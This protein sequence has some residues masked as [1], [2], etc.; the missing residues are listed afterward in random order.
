M[1][2]RYYTKN[3]YTYII[4]FHK[5]KKVKIKI[6]KKYLSKIKKMKNTWVVN[7]IGNYYYAL[8]R[9]QSNN[10]RKTLYIHR[11]IMQNELEEKKQKYPDTDWE[12]DH[13][14]RNGLNNT[15]E[16]LRVV[17]KNVN[18]LNSN[19]EGKRSNSGYTGIYKI[20]LTNRTKFEVHFRGKYIALCDTLEEAL[21]ERKL[22][23]ISYQDTKN[24]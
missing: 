14:D 9:K 24:E 22:A 11:V 15:R 17:S 8:Q 20:K 18:L 23:E 19:R 10:D 3:K 13:I 7:Q 21:H 6:N 2:N 1:K 4:A 16:N 12:V 5:G